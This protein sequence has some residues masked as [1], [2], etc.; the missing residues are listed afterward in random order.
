[1]ASRLSTHLNG[2]THTRPR[3]DDSCV[4][5]PSGT[6][7]QRPAQTTPNRVDLTVGHLA[8]AENLLSM[9]GSFMASEFCLQSVDMQSKI[10]H[11]RRKNENDLKWDEWDRQMRA[12]LTAPSNEDKANAML[13]VIEEEKEEEKAEEKEEE[14][15]T[16]VVISSICPPMSEI[17]KQVENDYSFCNTC[18]LHFPPEI[19]P[20]T[21]K[22]FKMC[23]GCRLKFRMKAAKRKADET[24]Q[25]E[26]YE[27]SLKPVKKRARKAKAVKFV[28]QQCETGQLIPVRA[29]T[30]EKSEGNSELDVPPTAE[31]WSEMFASGFEEQMF[32]ALNKKA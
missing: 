1:M 9:I 3:V 11:F 12:S 26:A 22:P 32:S 6:H 21:K 5:V 17:I 30:E 20:L 14:K 10:L 23:A 31:E 18:K 25:R 8:G 2:S 24:V 7:S 4:I 16:D 29:D 19:S 27:A 15:S 13:P 28:L